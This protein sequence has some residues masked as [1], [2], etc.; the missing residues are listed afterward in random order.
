M[1]RVVFCAVMA[2]VATSVKLGAA[3]HHDKSSDDKKHGHDKD[4]DKK[5]GHGH[6]HD[7]EP[8]KG[9]FGSEGTFC[10]NLT[11]AITS[12][13]G[14]CIHNFKKLAA[15]GVNHWQE[16]NPNF[17]THCD[18]ADQK[19][20]NK[21]DEALEKLAISGIDGA[22]N[23]CKNCKMPFNPMDMFNSFMA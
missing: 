2:S 19:M 1:K 3:S 22:I 16:G 13:G 15:D 10:E 6:G 4:D 23:Y 8:K 9:A 20:I 17:D 18:K 21:A 11:N 7:H 14:M 12:V 5:H